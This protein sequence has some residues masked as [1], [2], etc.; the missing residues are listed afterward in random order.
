MKALSLAPRRRAAAGAEFRRGGAGALNPGL[1]GADRRRNR[2]SRRLHGRGRGLAPV[3]AAL[4]ADGVAGVAGVIEGAARGALAFG[5][6]RCGRWQGKDRRS[7]ARRARTARRWPGRSHSQPEGALALH[8]RRRAGGSSPAL[9]A[10]LALHRRRGAGRRRRRGRRSHSHPE[11]ARRRALN[12]GA[13][14]LA[15]SIRGW[16]ARIGAETGAL[17]AFTGAGAGRR[18]SSQRCARAVRRRRWRGKDR[19]C[20]R[21]H[22]QPEAEAAGAR[23]RFV[24]GAASGRTRPHHRGAQGAALA[25]TRPDPAASSPALRALALATRRR[26]GTARRCGRSHSQPEGALARRGGAGA[27][28]RTPKARGGGR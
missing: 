28:T 4:R 11:G 1:A 21:S 19:R 25:F 5:N 2:R 9:R 20:G 7:Q 14:A 27:L 15:L 6:R 16:P 22:S 8:R 13:A 18:P 26:A 3:F 23:G 12:S 17:V 24:A 10:A